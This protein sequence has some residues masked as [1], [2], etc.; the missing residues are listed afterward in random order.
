MFKKE[1]PIQDFTV[2]KKRGLLKDKAQKNARI[3]LKA[4]F[5]DLTQ[6][7][8]P[9]EPKEQSSQ[10]SSPFTLLDNVLA[11]T[12]TNPIQTPREAST[13]TNSTEL[14]NLKVKLEDLEYKLSNLIDR[15][16]VI[17]TK[18]QNLK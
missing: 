9:P 2:L 4:G 16:L 12:N 7:Q 13:E 14:T 8:Q 17:E 3:S 10:P 11:T 1:A 15:L 18:L 5:L 6:S